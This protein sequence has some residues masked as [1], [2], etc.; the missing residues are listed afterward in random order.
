M[1][2]IK[3]YHRKVLPDIKINNLLLTS[4]PIV[5]VN[6][7]NIDLPLDC[8]LNSFKLATKEE[9]PY[10]QL[11]RTPKGWLDFCHFLLFQCQYF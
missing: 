1:D 4:P 10:H 7:D 5:Q 2:G 6:K 8:L 3:D 11:L 9:N